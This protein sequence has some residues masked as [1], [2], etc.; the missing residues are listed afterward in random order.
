MVVLTI[1]ANHALQPVGKCLATSTEDTCDVKDLPG[2]KNIQLIPLSRACV[3]DGVIASRHLCGALI[4]QRWHHLAHVSV[5]LELPITTIPRTGQNLW[6]SLLSHHKL[7]WCFVTKT[8]VPQW[9][10][11]DMSTP[12]N[13]QSG[14]RLCPY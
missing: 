1:V 9:L 12:Y 14:L 10:Q 13:P 11:F 5:I 7:Y 2:S 3:T 4:T 6:L 8:N